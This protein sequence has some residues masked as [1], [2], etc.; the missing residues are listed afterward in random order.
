MDKKIAIVLPAYNEEKNLRSVLTALTNAS[1]LTACALLVVDDGSKDTTAEIV[2]RFERVTLVQHP[3]NWGLAAA[4]RTAVDWCLEHKID[5]MVFFDADGQFDVTDIIRVA[6]PVLDNTCDFTLGSR[7]I[8]GTPAQIPAMKLFG[9]KAL[10][11]FISAITKQHIHDVACGFRA[12][13]REALLRI[14]LTGDF[15]YTQEVI[16]DLLFK[17]KRCVEVPI[18]VHYGSEIRASAISSNL[19]RYGWR[20]LKIMTRTIR[21]YQPMKFF[22]MIGGILFLA[23]LILDIWLLHYYVTAGSFTPYKAVGFTGAFLNFTG[24]TV[25]FVGLVADMLNRMRKNQETIIY[26]AKK[27]RYSR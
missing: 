24:L 27:E 8:N 15:T 20:V 13:S 23:G 9:N 1:D 18:T 5:V 2:Q 10:A 21:D 3:V 4:F 25:W 12:Y 26:L 11:R 22:G 6:Q 14:N 17:G 7:F 19:W 16:L